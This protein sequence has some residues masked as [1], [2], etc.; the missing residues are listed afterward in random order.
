MPKRIDYQAKALHLLEAEHAGKSLLPQLRRTC[1]GLCRQLELDAAHRPLLDL[2]GTSLNF[3]EIANQQIVSAEIMSAIGELAGMPCHGT[4]IHAG[5]QH[6][7]GYLL[8]VIETPYGFKRDRWISDTIEQSLDITQPTLRPWPTSGSLLI[9]V[10]YFLGRIAFRGR[11]SELTL[12]RRH[13][14]AVSPE[15]VGFA[16]QSLHVTRVTEHVCLP[17]DSAEVEVHLDFVRFPRATTHATHL[18][19]YSIVDNREERASLITA[20]P[21]T[22]TLLDEYT[23][24]EA[25]G[26]SVPMRTRFN[27]YVEGWTGRELVGE[28]QLFEA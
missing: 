2:W 24:T 17:H 11:S 8:S 9:N 16:F 22:S 12:L 13:Q 25:L 20:F 7:Y 26:K 3:D 1:P 28:R 18:L 19:V 10:T 6:T 21:V 23:S 5:L 4:S 15:A 27:A 14:T